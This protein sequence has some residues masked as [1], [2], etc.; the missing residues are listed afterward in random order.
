MGH[1]VQIQGQRYERHNF[2]FN[3]GFLLS[4]SCDTKNLAPLVTKLASYFK[5]LETE[6]EFLSTESTQLQ[7]ANIL[8][9]VFDHDL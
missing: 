2:F 7:V 6:A 8:E 1:P 4:T 5:T 3:V 9:E